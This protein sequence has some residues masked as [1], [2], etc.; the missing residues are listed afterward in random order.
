[1]LDRPR[2]D[3]RCKEL[4]PPDHPMLPAGERPDHLVDGKGGR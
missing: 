3:A 2:A 4:P 1:M